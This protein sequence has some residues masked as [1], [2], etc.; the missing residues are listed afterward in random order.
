V[1]VLSCKSGPLRVLAP[2][3]GVAMEAEFRDALEAEV[4]RLLPLRDEALLPL[5]LCRKGVF[6]GGIVFGD[7]ANID[8]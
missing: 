7:N 5:A 1:E 2:G 8:G 6:E 3:T 4:Q